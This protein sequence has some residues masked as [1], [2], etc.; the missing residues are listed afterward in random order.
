M[1]REDLCIKSHD[2]KQFTDKNLILFIMDVSF[3]P[4]NNSIK[5]LAV[6]VLEETKTG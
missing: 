1:K 6:M 2:S 5:R 3:L 4:N